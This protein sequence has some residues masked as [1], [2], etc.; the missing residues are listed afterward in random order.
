M[1]PDWAHVQTFIAVAELGSLSS[2]ARVLGSSQPTMGRHI[3]AL[4]AALGV[5]LFQRTGGGLELTSTG[6][7]LLEPARRMSGAADRLALIAQ[8]RAEILAGSIR[9]A[10]SDIVA[11]YLLPDMLTDLRK[12]EPEIDIE[13]VASDRT[14]NL[15]RREADIALRMYRPD[16]AEVITRKVAELSVGA[17]AAPSYLE[18]R[19]TPRRIDEFLHHDIIGYDRSDLIIKG[20]QAAGVPVSRDFF[21]FRSDNQVVAWRMVVAGFGIGFNQRLVGDREPR[22]RQVELAAEMPSLP[23]WLT[24]HSELKTSRRV[25][26]VYDFLAE[27]FRL[28]A[29]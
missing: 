28:L 24:A 3:A 2:A 9:I 29:G 22:V 25:R 14:E 16:Q 8:G 1:R 18:R 6:L 27:R 26:R 13:L 21:A 11:T 12:T 17:Y 7:D 23:V 19:G 10:A 20:F 4:E 15:L 5:Q